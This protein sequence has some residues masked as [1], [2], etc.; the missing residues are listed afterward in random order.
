MAGDDSVTAVAE[1]YRLFARRE[2]RG[3]SPA[4]EA[5]AEAVADDD[6]VTGFVASLFTVI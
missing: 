1:A 5:L 6:A 2:A 3:R 4:Y